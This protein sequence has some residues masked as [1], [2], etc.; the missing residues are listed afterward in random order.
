MPSTPKSSRSGAA[1]TSKGKVRD[2]FT[3]RVSR[4]IKCSEITRNATEEI[5]RI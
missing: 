2:V 3:E 5:L 1:A 4:T